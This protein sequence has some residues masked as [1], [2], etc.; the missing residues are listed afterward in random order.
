MS[1]IARTSLFYSLAPGAL[2]SRA[3]AA[4]L[5]DISREADV[6]T[7]RFSE[8]LRACMKS[9][10]GTLPSTTTRF[11]YTYFRFFDEMSSL[12]LS[13]SLW[14]ILYAGRPRYIPPL[15]SGRPYYFSFS[16][17]IPEEKFRYVCV[18]IWLREKDWI[19]LDWKFNRFSAE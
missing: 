8:K 15:C 7:F 6:I 13:L 5:W 4:A 3:R 18:Y 14:V 9:P 11:L 1:C 2:N 12:S 17:W 16:R 10:V 19:W